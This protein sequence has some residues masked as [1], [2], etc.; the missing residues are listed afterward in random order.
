[1]ISAT[2]C[3]TA[4]D[5][6]SEMRPNRYSSDTDLADILYPPGR[7][8]QGLSLLFHGLT[9]EPDGRRADPRPLAA[10]W[11]QMTTKEVEHQ[12]RD[13]CALVF[14]REVS[15]V[16]QMQLGL[17]QIA[18]V[19]TRALGG[20]LPAGPFVFRPTHASRR[21]KG[22]FQRAGDLISSPL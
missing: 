11:S 6:G 3:I 17:R 1:M 19:R 8:L 4:M 2:T 21:N 13:L 14:E 7:V 16:E 20:D 5:T 15:S 12:C 9:H 22:L 10:A 18:Q